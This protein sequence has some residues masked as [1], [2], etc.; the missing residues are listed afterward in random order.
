MALEHSKCLLKSV[1]KAFDVAVERACGKDYVELVSNSV[2]L[3][4]NFYPKGCDMVTTCNQRIYSYHVARKRR[5]KPNA[6][7]TVENEKEDQYV[8]VDFEIMTVPTYSEYG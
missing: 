5:E 8:N 2:K 6:I 7:E 1:Q 4:I 3:S